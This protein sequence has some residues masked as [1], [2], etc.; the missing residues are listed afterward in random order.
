MQR[1]IAGDAAAAF[2]ELLRRFRLRAALSQEALA[3]RAGLSARAIS[4]LER[5]IHRAP[6]GDTVRLLTEALALSAE[7]RAGLEAAV[8]R[9]RR[10]AAPRASGVLRGDLTPPLTSLLVGR[11]RD[12]AAVTRLLRR[13]DVRLLT[14]TGPGGVGKTWL[15][16]QVA[17]ELADDLAGG[18]M[19]VGLAS[20]REP[21]ELLP[22]IARALGLR[23][24]GSGVVADVLAA[25]LHGR[26]LLILLDNFEHLLGAAPALPPLLAACPRLKLLITSRSALGLRGE[27]E[28]AVPPLELPARADPRPPEA[29]A[30]APAIKLF[31]Q[32]LQAI[33]P[34]FALTG[35]TAPLV[36][37]I[38]RRLDGLP[39]AIE[40]AA[41]R[42]RV[43]S[44]AALLARLDQRLPMLAEGARD[45]PDRHQ[46]LRRAIAWSYDLLAPAEQALFRRLGVCAGGCTSGAAAALRAAEGPGDEASTLVALASLTWQSLLL[47]E[48]QGEGEPRFR[49]LE[50]VR[51]FAH[52]QLSACGEAED[53]AGRHAA[54]FLALAEAAA[55]P[56]CGGNWL[57]WTRRLD[58]EQDNLRTAL[59]RAD[60][61]GDVETAQRLVAALW[62][63]FQR[64]R[65]REG[66]LWTERALALPAADVPL[67]TRAAALFAAG[68]L[69]MWD[70]DYQKARAAIARSVTLWREAGDGRGLA[71]AHTWLGILSDQ[72]ETLQEAAALARQ[73][74]DDWC[75]GVALLWQGFRITMGPQPSRARACFEEALPI[76]RRVGEPFLLA[77]ALGDLGRLE[78]LEGEPARARAGF[79]EAL[80]IARQGG[81]R[82]DIATGLAN[83]G[84][85]ALLEG[86]GGR[87]SAWYSD[88]LRTTLGLDEQPLPEDAAERQARIAAAL[89]AA[90][91]LGRW[92]FH[93]LEGLGCAGVLCGEAEHGV[94]LLAAAGA[95]RRQAG[96]PGVVGRRLLT[97]RAATAAR[98][99]LGETAYAATGAA[100]ALLSQPGATVLALSVADTLAGFP[101]A[102][103]RSAAEEP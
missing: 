25:Q 100:G 4:D 17:L 1:P 29:L 41:A 64:G 22:A 55:E 46:T 12:Q 95:L 82:R 87:A 56:L 31:V 6:Y 83:L 7:E 19:S 103:R 43:L 51:E 52:E 68:A 5:G 74:G 37:Q 32:R 60:E 40:L 26:E 58:A 101:P 13:A 86:D 75:L 54:V 20:L 71:R 63:W 24:E 18:A 89:R 98:A 92:G 72:Q 38:C 28:F 67:V 81:H 78:L 62:L 44:P 88:S 42:G 27:Q 91:G 36:A 93:A 3:E 30:Q 66:R 33:Q 39:L 49:M 15:A 21:A 99:V 45:A 80:A 70:T 16:P 57:P 79:A 76:A 59:L 47:A 102:S 84:A 61:R 35:E 14:L 77:N 23:D 96:D 73:A 2:G 65:L 50:T 94:R 97:E 69:A 11:E 48:A 34:G 8:D 9:H 90:G 53:A 85:V 10:P